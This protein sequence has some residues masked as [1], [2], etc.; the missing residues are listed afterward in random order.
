M[1]N[2]AIIQQLTPLLYRLSLIA[3]SL[4]NNF[5]HS[6][7]YQILSNYRDVVCKEDSI[8][9]LLLIASF[10]QDC[11]SLLENDCEITYLTL[12]S[13]LKSSSSLL[14][15]LALFHTITQ[16]CQR[17]RDFIDETYPQLLA[18]LSEVVELLNPKRQQEFF[19]SLN[20]ASPETRERVIQEMIKACTFVDHG[21]ILTF[22]QT[23]LQ[24]TE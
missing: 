9:S 11:F 23:L 3:P 10:Y 18:V 4:I 21:I 5:V 2:P 14:H 12:L 13:S 8:N 24:V 6:V 7:V 1:S 17:K 20:E 15:R 19:L 16:L 22:L